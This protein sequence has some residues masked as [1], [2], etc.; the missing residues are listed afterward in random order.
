MRVRIVSSVVKCGECTIK[1]GVF[2]AGRKGK[3]KGGR[4][5]EKRKGGLVWCVGWQK[6]EILV[7]SNFIRQI[8]ATL[9]LP[10]DFGARCIHNPCFQYPHTWKQIM[11]A[12]WTRGYAGW[13]AVTLSLGFGSLS[14]SHTHTFSL[15]L[16]RWVWNLAYWYEA[17]CEH[18]ET[19]I[20]IYKIWCNRFTEIVI[21]AARV[22]RGTVRGQVLQLFRSC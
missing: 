8:R 3:R 1:G 5:R 14:I 19:V 18:V 7:T 11:C 10:M 6:R 20:S 15:Y 17:G 2:W 12:P 9:Q 22:A 21:G 16:D 13:T 4:E